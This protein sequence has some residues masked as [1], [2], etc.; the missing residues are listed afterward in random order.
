MAQTQA[1]PEHA[2]SFR[3]GSVAGTPVY[4][5]RS[6]FFIAVVIAFVVGPQV[7]SFVDGIASSAA[8][9]VGLG[10]AALLLGS[11]FLHELA[12]AVA[13]RAV[14]TPPTDIVLD[15]WGGHTAFSEEIRT[16][17][18]SILVAA[19]GPLT[20]GL[21]AVVCGV[22]A[23]VATDGGVVRGV[24]LMLAYTNGFVAVL[25]ALPGLP[26]D[27]GRVLEGV[28]WAVSRS[29]TTGTVAAGR[30]G[31]AVAVAVVAWFVVRPFALGYQ[32][33]VITIVW[34]LAIGWMLWRGATG[35]IRYARFRRAAEDVSVGRLMRP[36]V[37][38]SGAASVADARAAVHAVR[39]YPPVTGVVPP[40]PLVVVLD[41]YGNPVGIVDETAA[42]AVPPERAGLVQVAS[43]G[44]GLP[45]LVLSPQLTGEDLL[46]RLRETPAAEYAVVDGGRVVGVLDWRTVAA[47]VGAG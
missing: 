15:L 32:P 13:A 28:V 11:V 7:A 33:G 29:R 9:L 38:V 8:Y 6:W 14:G 12:H 46:S 41:G 4:L 30:I 39:P 42:A 25:N 19:V 5:R 21:L 45:P 22:L 17:G 47:V 35:S 20:N 44:R 18:R 40:E 10:F 1:P 36:A 34:S 16:P 37:T 26:L 31:Q 27:G 2:G 3:L 43:V 23:T 24:L